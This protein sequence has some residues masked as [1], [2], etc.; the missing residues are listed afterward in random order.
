MFEMLYF[1]IKASNIGQYIKSEHISLNEMKS[2]S[3]KEFKQEFSGVVKRTKWIHCVGCQ[4]YVSGETADQEYFKNHLDPKNDPDG[5]KHAERVSKHSKDFMRIV[6]YELAPYKREVLSEEEVSNLE[7][8]F[9]DKDDGSRL[10]DTIEKFIHCKTCR[11]VFFPKKPTVQDVLIHLE[12]HK[13]NLQ[14]GGGSDSSRNDSSRNAKS[15]TP[16][17]RSSSQVRDDGRF[18]ERR[19]LIHSGLLQVLHFDGKTDELIKTEDI[20]KNQASKANEDFFMK[21][22]VTGTYRRIRCV[23]CK[24]DYDKPCPAHLNSTSHKLNMRLYLATE[25]EPEGDQKVENPDEADGTIQIQSMYVRMD[26]EEVFK[27]EP[28]SKNEAKNLDDAFF[29]QDPV[30]G[31]YKQ[32]KCVPCGKSWKLSNPH[33]F[34]SIGHKLKHK[35]Y[36][37][38][39]EENPWLSRTRN[40]SVQC[41]GKF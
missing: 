18:N 19:S 12:A 1:D 8:G 27:T 6:Y 24:K 37:S 17:I 20:S 3:K 23:P 11:K 38:N 13:I 31:F 29:L 26:E 21:S 32:L 16:E 15:R 33:H 4:T 22:L 28:I 39:Q 5:I 7:Q 2:S 35:V 30:T 41:I 25:N 36:T 10:N 34:D 9:L 40:S 14:L